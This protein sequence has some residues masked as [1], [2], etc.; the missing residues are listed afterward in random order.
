MG[1]SEEVARCTR[2]AMGGEMTFREALEQRLNLMKPSKSDLNNYLANHTIQMTP[3]VIDLVAE[4]HR[5]NVDVYLVLFLK[6]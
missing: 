4:L 1:V 3:G 6:F 2:N 5:R